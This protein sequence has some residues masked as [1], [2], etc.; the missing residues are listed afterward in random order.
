MVKHIEIGGK[1][2]PVLYSIN[3]L[4][5]FEELTGHDMLNTS[6]N[7]DL[8]SL[9]KLRALAFVG[10]KYGAK[11]EGLT[12]KIELDTVGD[13][14]SLSD[15]SITEF[16]SAFRTSNETESSPSPQGEGRDEGMAEAT[17]KN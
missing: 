7:M 4:I 12:E 11:H 17:P 3:A 6:L 13:W 8:R 2:R 9:K 16:V 10:L 15:G 1:S 5:E 14:L